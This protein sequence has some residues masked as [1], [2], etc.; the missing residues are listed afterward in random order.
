MKAEPRLLNLVSNPPKTY[1]GQVVAVA[2][3][4]IR[5]NSATHS[6]PW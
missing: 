5:L 4:G 2:H 6:M 3:P 1:Q